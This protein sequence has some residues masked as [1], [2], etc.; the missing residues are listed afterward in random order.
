MLF[1]TN[2]GYYQNYTWY[3]FLWQAGGDFQNA[4][5][6]SAFNSPGGGSRR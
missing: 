3:P 6:K 5:G 2:P 4:D 1:E